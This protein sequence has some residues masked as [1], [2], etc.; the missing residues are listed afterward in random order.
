MGSVTIE[1]FAG[2]LEHLEQGHQEA[3]RAFG[4]LIFI[5]VRNAHP[6]ATAAGFE[7]VQRNAQA[8]GAEEPCKGFAHAS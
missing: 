3:D 6:V 5:D 2:Q 8:V 7:V 4:T 1:L